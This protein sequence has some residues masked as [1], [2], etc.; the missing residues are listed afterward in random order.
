[1]G[2][3]RNLNVKLPHRGVQ[4]D[5]RAAKSNLSMLHAGSNKGPVFAI[6]QP[7]Q[8]RSLASLAKGVS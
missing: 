1:M 4:E 5:S 2:E 6:S 3:E 7:T 8:K